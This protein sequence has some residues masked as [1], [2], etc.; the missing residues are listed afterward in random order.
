MTTINREIASSLSILKFFKPVN[1][2]P[3]AEQT[4]LLKHAVCS[5]NHAVKRMLEKDN[6]QQG[7]A[8]TRKT[9]TV[10][11]CANYVE[12]GVAKA[13]KHFE[14]LNLHIVLVIPQFLNHN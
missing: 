12:N 7:N 5:V 13:H 1:S 3:T 4:K 11:D 9:F 8:S 14:Q 6:C 10:K 2:L